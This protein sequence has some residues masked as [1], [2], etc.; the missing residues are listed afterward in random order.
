MQHQVKVASIL[1]ILFVIA[2]VGTVAA[3][4]IVTTLR[5]NG[6]E[7]AMVECTSG[8]NLAVEGSPDRKAALQGASKATPGTQSAA[9]KPSKELRLALRPI[10]VVSPELHERCVP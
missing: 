3:Q 9:S 2:I 8:R 4:T 1:A 5:L 7:S 6:G 10:N